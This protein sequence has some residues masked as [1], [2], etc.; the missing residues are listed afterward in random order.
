MPIT[1]SVGDGGVNVEKD[2]KYVQLLLNVFREK[3]GQTVLKVDGLVGPKTLKA[4]EDFQQ[5]RTAFH[6]DRIDPDGPTIKALEQQIAGLSREMEA[7]LAIA[8]ALSYDPRFEGPPP[9]ANSSVLAAIV[10][11]IFAQRG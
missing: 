11:S 3:N 7:Y 4:I 2:V 5:A 1:Q 10:G 8:I 9:V 6:D